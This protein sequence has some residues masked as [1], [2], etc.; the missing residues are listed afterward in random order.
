MNNLM[1][2][3][4]NNVSFFSKK[5][6]IELWEGERPLWEA[7]FV[8]GAIVVVLAYV[9]FPLLGQFYPALF[10]F[11]SILI[12]FMQIFWWIS[13]CRCAQNSSTF[14]QYLSRGVVL[15]GAL[16]FLGQLLS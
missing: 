15:A 7:W 11:L 5:W 4:Y 8:L 1:K 16:G 13:V 2:K 3:T 6:F 12:I 10:A 14:F 9:L